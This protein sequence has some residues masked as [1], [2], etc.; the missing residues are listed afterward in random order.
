MLLGGYDYV[1]NM[2][3]IA[4]GGCDM[5]LGVQWL[6]TVSPVLGDFQLLTLE[7]KKMSNSYKLH[8][9]APPKPLVKNKVYNS[10]IRKFLIPIWV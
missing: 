1:I 4:L 8:R 3:Y 2:F 10:L 5:V 9:S 6:S 7:F